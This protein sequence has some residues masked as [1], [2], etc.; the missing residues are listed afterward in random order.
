MCGVQDLVQAPVA[1]HVVTPAGALSRARPST[2]SSVVRVRAVVVRVR[3]HFLPCDL[4]LL[5]VD[6]Y[7]EPAQGLPQAVLQSM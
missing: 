1:D 7:Y 6:H 4:A 3:V 2:G 5:G